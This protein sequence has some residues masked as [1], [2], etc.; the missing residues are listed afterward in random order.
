MRNV[1]R[2]PMCRDSL[3]PLGSIYRRGTYFTSSSNE[4]V[5]HMTS[6]TRE[7]RR[8]HLNEAWRTEYMSVGAKSRGTKLIVPKEYCT[9]KWVAYVGALAVVR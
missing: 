3:R 2:K 6:L 9:S 1:L 5:G 8:P 4:L 7:A